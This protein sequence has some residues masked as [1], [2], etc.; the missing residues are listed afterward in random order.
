VSASKFGDVI[1]RIGNEIGIPDLCPDE[2]GYCDLS[3]DEIGISILMMDSYITLVSI[4]GTVPLH[5]KVE[6]YERLLDANYL[7]RI[8][9]G[10][11]L[12]MRS[13][14]GDVVIQAQRELEQLSH[15]DIMAWLTQF[16]EASELWRQSM[17]VIFGSNTEMDSG[18]SAMAG[19]LLHC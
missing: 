17:E 11:T 18:K 15:Q 9:S 10:C 4:L 8:T 13:S 19:R 6:I 16:I 14:T 5:A 3:I 12:A 2:Y 1:S 7:W